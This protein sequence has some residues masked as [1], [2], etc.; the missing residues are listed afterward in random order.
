V[1]C[2]SCGEILPLSWFPCTFLIITH[3]PLYEP[4]HVSNA[5]A[6]NAFKNF[7]FR[8]KIHSIREKKGVNA[9]KN[10][11]QKSHIPLNLSIEMDM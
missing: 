3:N 1:S 6:W 4:L 9:M 5:G 11:F 7:T 2:W 10:P 8:Y